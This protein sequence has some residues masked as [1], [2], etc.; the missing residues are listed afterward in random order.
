MA[1]KRG[2]ASDGAARLKGLPGSWHVLPDNPYEYPVVRPLIL[3][4]AI[5]Q[6]D[7]T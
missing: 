4:K 3:N 2:V 6:I 5:H 1:G 7:N